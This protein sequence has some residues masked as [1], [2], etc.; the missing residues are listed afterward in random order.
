MA[1][2][3]RY[4]VL[5]E[6][7]KIGPVTARNRFYQVPHC[8]GMGR[9]FPTSSAVMRGIKAEGGW[10]VISTE[11]CDFHPTGDVRTQIRLWDE[12]D[13]PTH[14]RMTE[15]V[16]RHGSLAAVELCHPGHHSASFYAR[17]TPI[18]PSPIP[19]RAPFPGQARAMDRQDIADFRKWHRRAAVLA[20]QAGFDIVY[21]YA[22]HAI[23]LLMF[24]LSRQYNQRS[25]EYGGSLENRARLFR[26]CIEDAHDAVGESCAVAV[27][28]A[29]DEL[30]GENGMTAGAEGRELVEMLAE[31]PDLWDV[32]ISA[33]ENDSATSRFAPEGFQEQYIDFV[34]SVTT[35]PVVGVGRF[36]SPDSMVSQIKRGVLDFIGAARPSIADPFLPKKIEEGHLDD[37]RECIGCNICAAYNNASVPL[38]CTQNPTQGEEWR[39]G[40]HPERIAAKN[41]D[42][43]VL[44]VGAGPAGL[45]AA[46]ALGQRGYQVLL[47]EAKTEIGG[48][49][50]RESR[51]PGL[52]AWSRVLDYRATQL[53]QMA[54]VKI[55]PGS[56]MSISDVL[57]TDCSLVAIATGASWARDGVG[58]TL[59]QAVPGAGSSNIYTPDDIMADVEFEGPVAIY[60]DDHYYMGSVI[61]EMLRHKGLDVTLITPSSVVS[62]FSTY[63][64]EQE[65][66][67]AKLLTLGVRIVPQQNL[68]AV[69]ADGVDLACVYT[70]K[71]RHVEA[72]SIVLVTS[73]IPNDE[74]YHALLRDE[75]VIKQSGIDKVTRIGDC[76]APSIIADA[77]YAGHKYARDLGAEAPEEVPFKR[78]LIELTP[79]Y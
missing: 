68:V 33:W 23:T 20:Q 48:R 49:V 79:D 5:F 78:E 4:D 15:L 73:R 56:P 34:K 16:H 71:P 37:I 28:L 70:G 50:I 8:S 35:K 66:V 53:R 22:G 1:R 29:V 75:A 3:R 39:K 38:R 54:N 14:A 55:Y 43:S 47:A 52:S 2:D 41:T 60:D 24:F 42:D 65:H 6:P 67:Q 77:V 13:I 40:W 26:E 31:L 36:T 76:Y 21:V 74:L 25:D 30:L 18:A 46:R 45:E 10:A 51:L 17:E 62:E 58:R 44:I 69:S 27:R 32:N 9:Q 12:K 19:V 64:L 7:V 61:A 72:A 59:H 63:T 57:E 11:Q